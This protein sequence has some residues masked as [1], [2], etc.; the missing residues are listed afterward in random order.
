VHGGHYYAFI[1]PSQPNN[2]VSDPEHDFWGSIDTSS[3]TPSFNRG[4]GGQWF[5]FDDEIV[6]T[7]TDSEAINNMFGRKYLFY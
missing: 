3:H 2:P 7:V 6:T 5:R 1:R 4:R